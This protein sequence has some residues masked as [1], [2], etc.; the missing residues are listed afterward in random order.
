MYALNLLIAE[1]VRD[2]EDEIFREEMF[3]LEVTIFQIM[4]CIIHAF[5]ISLNKNKE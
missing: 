3:R 5:R 2:N 1:T 4:W